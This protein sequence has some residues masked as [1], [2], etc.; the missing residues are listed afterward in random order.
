MLPFLINDL[1]F[2]FSAQRKKDYESL[3]VLRNTV[4]KFV[5]EV[6]ELLPEITQ[7]E[8]AMKKKRSSRTKRLWHSI[9]CLRFRS[10][11]IRRASRTRTMKRSCR[12]S[13]MNCSRRN[14][15]IF[16]RRREWTMNRAE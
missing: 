11:I 5:N 9:S 14:L 7:D 13:L 12:E 4:H 8:L 1:H 6:S 2:L 16:W 10:L 3:I 15:L